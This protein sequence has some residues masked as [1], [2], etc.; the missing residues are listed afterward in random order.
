MTKTR[1]VALPASVVLLGAS[2]SGC[3]IFR[4][5]NSVRGSGNVV[6]ESRPISGVNAVALAA[7]ASW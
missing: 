6:T 1:F 7:L 2:V 3:G 5:P 4:L